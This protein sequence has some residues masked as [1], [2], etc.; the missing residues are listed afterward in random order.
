MNSQLLAS[1]PL[2]AA[3]VMLLVT[4]VACERR[5]HRHRQP[6]VSY[7]DATL[8]LDGGWRRPDLFTAEGLRLQRR[9]SRC[10]VTGAGLLLA[11]LALWVVL[12]SR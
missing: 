1:V 2:A 3:G 5:M 7:A 12:G 11:S 6:G 8:R 9:A 10:G 4:A